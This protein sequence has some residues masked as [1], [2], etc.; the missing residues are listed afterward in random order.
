MES[1][2]R[3]LPGP[4]PAIIR[5]GVTAII[6]LLAYAVR[7]SMGEGTGRYGFIHFV[8]PIVAASLLFGRGSGFFAIGLSIALIAGIL[9]WD[10]NVTPHILAIGVFS[11]VGGCLVFL[12]EGFRTALT[13]AHAAQQAANLL[14][15][16]MSHRV[17]NKFSMI[18]SII[19]LQA[20]NSAPDVRRALE[21]VAARVNVMATVHNYL[22]LSRHDGLI[23]MAEYLPGLCEALREALC[24]PRPITLTVRA[25]PEHLPADKA[26]TAG[27]IVN[28]LV[29]NAFK[30]AFDP[31]RPGA[32]VV[33][34]S[35]SE[36]GLDLSVTDNGRGLTA[37]HQ[38]G[39]GTRL[40]NVLAAQ[41]G[42]KAE[43]MAGSDGGCRARVQFPR[44]NK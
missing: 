44:A 25:I 6:V 29:T 37:D 26:L 40:V 14:L 17:K 24:G 38:T 36:S 9:Q 18:T 20:R 10:A 34:L 27:L 43:W 2:F 7:F 8:L 21:D 41:L 12:A 3:F 39:L 30:Y 11:L 5:F 35:P 1:L 28:E 13:K 15:Q 19:F 31:N 33:E 23:D 16:E 32:V 22:Q 4:Q 42:G